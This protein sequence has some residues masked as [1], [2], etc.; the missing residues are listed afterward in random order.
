MLLK[1]SIVTAER[2]ISEEMFLG[3]L[4]SANICRPCFAVFEQSI[5]LEEAHEKFGWV[6]LS[7]ATRQSTP[8]GF[9][10]LD[11]SINRLSHSYFQFFTNLILGGGLAVLRSKGLCFRD[12][13]ISISLFARTLNTFRV[14]GK[15][16]IYGQR[17]VPLGRILTAG[18]L[19]DVADITRPE[20]L[21]KH[22]YLARALYECSH[23]R[24][25]IYGK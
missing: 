5:P 2:S 19:A 6:L 20:G 17:P 23:M 18:T 10:I 7:N 15:P 9:C 22:P 3:E 11:A 25:D 13:G 14:F 8:Y 21:M 12:G 4:L 24:E 1:N 16:K